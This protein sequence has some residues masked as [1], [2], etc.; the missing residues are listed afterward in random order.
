M[1]AEEGA[2]VAVTARTKADLEELVSEIEEHGV[3]GLSVPADLREEG[4]IDRLREK[5]YDRF[6]TVEVLV[7]NAGVGK[8]GPFHELTAEDYDWMMDTNMRSSF[9]CTKAFTPQMM[10]RGIG[11]VVFLGSVAGLQSFRNESI[12]CATKH[13]Q[14]AFARSL[15][16]EVRESGVKV[17]VIAPGG[18]NTEFAF[19]TGRSP[20][21]EH[22]D[23]FLEPETVAD[24]VRYVVTQPPK[25]RVF[26]VG[27]RPMSEEL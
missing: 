18:V 7:N 3:E 22:L 23:E 27:M 15:D 12:Y 16:R 11:T 19:G 6:G 24:A 9:L 21:D 4:A 13:A 8:Y 1:L 20:G 17:S 5:V 2:D 25:S 10:D 14:M 26:L